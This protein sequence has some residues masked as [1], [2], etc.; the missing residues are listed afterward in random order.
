MITCFFITAVVGFFFCALSCEGF[1][2]PKTSHSC[3]SCSSSSQVQEGI[4][5]HYNSRADIQNSPSV[6]V[7][8]PL[9]PFTSTVLS[10]H[11][12]ITSPIHYI[13]SRLCF[14]L[15]LLLGMCTLTPFFPDQLY[16][17]IPQ[18]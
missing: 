7:A 12:L 8:L 17:E 14:C 3:L 15:S 5:Q 1:Q 4:W 9:P 11:L 10:S 16:T 13:S 6:L 2:H 18:I